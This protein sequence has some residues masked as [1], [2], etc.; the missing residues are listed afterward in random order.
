MKKIVFLVMVSLVLGSF[1]FPRERTKG[2]K[3]TDKKY[4]R[5]YEPTQRVFQGTTSSKPV[6]HD[7][8]RNGS[9]ITLIDS[10]SNGYGMIASATRP[11][12]V[13][14]DEEW[15]IA[16]R[17]YA[18]EGQTH[19]QLGFAESEDGEDWRVINNI[20]SNGAPPWGG[21]GVGGGG[22]AQARFPSASGTEDYP[23]AFW[24]EYTDIDSDPWCGTTDSYGG[25]PFY[26]YDTQGWDGGLMS[27]PA[28]TDPDWGGDCKD[29]W[30]GSSVMSFSD[31][32]DSYIAVSTYSDW[33]RNNNYMFALQS[34]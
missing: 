15:S 20:N 8:S 28:E 27:F 6:I 9:F 29:L 16:Y 17:Q 31:D 4:L 10:S 23:Y 21:G 14:V 19:G 26:S 2:I 30:A 3:T 11:L 12:F 32:E 25:M 7:N 34:I 22:S 24:N 5:K 1:V 33:T 13:S 18:G